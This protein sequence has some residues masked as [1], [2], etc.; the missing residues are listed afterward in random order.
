MDGAVHTN[1]EEKR[2]K[3]EPKVDDCLPW[4]RFDEKVPAERAE[5]P[6]A[7]QRFVFVQCHVRN[8]SMS[9]LRDQQCLID[10]YLAFTWRQRTT[11]AALLQR[12]RKGCA[13]QLD[14]SDPGYEAA[15][16]LIPKGE[17]KERCHSP[18]PVLLLLQ[19]ILQSESPSHFGVSVVS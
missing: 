13:G 4:G 3:A 1:G 8:M 6:P 17:L 7:T 12:T 18:L 15:L 2:D 11:D 16:Y 9:S 10:F 5:P 14:P 19:M